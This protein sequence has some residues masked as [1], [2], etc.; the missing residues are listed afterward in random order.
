MSI[1][2]D[3]LEYNFKNKRAF[4]VSPS[5][6]NNCKIKFDFEN[7]QISNTGSEKTNF[8]GKFTPRIN[9]TY[10]IVIEKIVIDSGTQTNYVPEI[11]DKNGNSV[12]RNAQTFSYSLKAF[13][14]YSIYTAS[15]SSGNSN[16]TVGVNFNVVDDTVY[17]LKG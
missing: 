4:G 13:N 17:I 7:I 12:S 5:N 15:S 10:Y 8:V 6:Y 3:M 14:E 9:G 1:H 16:I 2:D 11:K